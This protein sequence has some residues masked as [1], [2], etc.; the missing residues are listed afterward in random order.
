MPDLT[1]RARVLADAGIV[2]AKWGNEWFVFGAQ[3]AIFWGRPRYTLDV[4][5]TARLEPEDSAG[6]CA[7]M[8][9][10]GFRLKVQ[11]REGFVARTRVLPF[12]HVATQ[13]KLDVVL[14]GPGLEEL[15][16]QRSV[17]VDM[18]GVSIPI[19]SPEDLVAM[20]I[21]AG[22]AKDIEDVRAVL[23][24]RMKTLKIAQIR[25]T[26]GLLEQAL[27]QSD[28]LRQFEAEL[29]WVKKWVK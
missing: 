14:A 24:A 15:F 3:A 12:I 17:Q 28:L 4:D 11:D 26:L 20:K 10:S 23:A 16:L 18:D 19:V 7:D 9:R 8:E 1:D 5:V 25:T 29:S 6:F 13:M 21:L 22:R 2:L 27:A